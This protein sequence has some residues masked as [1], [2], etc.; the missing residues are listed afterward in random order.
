MEGVDVVPDGGVRLRPRRV[1]VK[2]G[3]ARTIAE[4]GGQQDNRKERRKD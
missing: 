4:P 2:V 1:P 3:H